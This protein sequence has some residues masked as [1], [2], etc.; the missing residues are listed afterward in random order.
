MTGAPTSLTLTFP[1]LATIVASRFVLN[2]IFRSSYPL[3]PFI[4]ARYGASTTAATWIVTIQVLAGLAS[5]LGGWLGDR[6]GYRQTMLLGLLVACLGVVGV[7][8]VDTLPLL[9]LSLACVGLGTTLYLP[10]MQAYVSVLTPFAQRGRAFGLVELAWSMAGILGVT[11]VVVLAERSDGLQLPYATLAVLLLVVLVLSWTALP[12]EARHAHAASRAPSLLHAIRQPGVRPLLVFFWLVICGTELLFIAQSPWLTDRFGATPQ[13]I[14]QALF[15]FG[16]G[17]LVGASLA[18]AFTDRLGKRRAPM[19]G[20]AAASL[21]YM[22]LP[23]LSGSWGSYLLLFALFG[24]TF[25]FG[26]VASFALASSVNPAAR[27]TTMAASTLAIT[28]GRAG[29]S[30]IGVRLYEST[31]ILLNGIVAAVVTWIGLIVAVNGLK[32]Q[33]NEH[34]ATESKAVT[35]L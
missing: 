12:R 33:E 25:E 7:A 1:R 28:T 20:F 23:L 9:V 26:I 27:G 5:P 34:E 2:T 4:A 10:S 21:V 14:G 31:N 24:L 30:W 19:A 32:S 35:I 17:E 6:H 8:L 15:I 22:L 13:S 11:P 16:L 3:V 29:G 18:T